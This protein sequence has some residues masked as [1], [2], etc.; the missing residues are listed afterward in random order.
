MQSGFI[1]EESCFSCNERLCTDLS[2]SR[3]EIGSRVV[4]GLAA[5][6]VEHVYGPEA[7]VGTQPIGLASNVAATD[8]A[9]EAIVGG[10]NPPEL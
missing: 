4:A 6:G 3:S 10:L 7:E 5:V 1:S 9:S 8:S 2:A